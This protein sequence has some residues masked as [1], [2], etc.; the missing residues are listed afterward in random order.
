MKPFQMLL[1]L[2]SFDFKLHNEPTDI[3]ATCSFTPYSASLLSAYRYNSPEITYFY[4]ILVPIFI[5]IIIFLFSNNRNCFFIDGI[6]RVN[7]INSADFHI[8][9][10][11]CSLSH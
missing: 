8:A 7:L 4:N 9:I 3:G 6:V 11:L 2:V 10:Y 5:R 1:F